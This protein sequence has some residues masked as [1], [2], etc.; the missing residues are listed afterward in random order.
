MLAEHTRAYASRSGNHDLKHDGSVVTIMELHLVSHSRNA[1]IFARH[2]IRY[3]CNEG[4]IIQGYSIYGAP[5]THLK[6]IR[7]VT[8]QCAL[9]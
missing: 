2:N 7:R 9:T 6:G 1:A 3:L 4:C 8:H 5:F